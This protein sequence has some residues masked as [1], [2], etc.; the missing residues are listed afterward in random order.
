[1]LSGV[2]PSWSR[3]RRLR[4]RFLRACRLEAGGG[5]FPVLLFHFP[6]RNRGHG[7]GAARARREKTV[8]APERVGEKV[9]CR[10]PGGAA[11]RSPLTPAGEG[12]LRSLLRAAARG[13]AGG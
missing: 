10:H 13:R 12:G 9:R 7:D 1:M 2:A 11:A 4:A 3:H 6:A 8:K 5:E